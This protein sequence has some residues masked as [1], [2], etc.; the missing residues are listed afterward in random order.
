[1]PKITLIV[2]ALL[3]V[4][5]LVGYFATGMASA[6]ALIPSF[7]GI[8]IG[9]CGLLALKPALRMHAM[10]GAV[11]FAL[12]GLGGTA[13]GLIQGLKSIFGDLELERPEAIAAQSVTALICLVFII[14]C[15]HSFV[16]A[17]LARKA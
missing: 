3:I 8:L 7:L 10:H 17:R 15:I 4:I 12:I 9:L 2:A 5:G 14:L 16:Q 1:M 6:T 11:L 13:R